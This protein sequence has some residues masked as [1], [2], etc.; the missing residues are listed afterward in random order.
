MAASLF[1]PLSIRGL[2]VKNR[3]AMS[4]MNRN[5][6]PAG[7]V[8]ENIAKF[9]RRRVDGDVGLIFTGGIAVDHPAA[10]GVYVD[11][12]CQVPLLHTPEA[13]AGWRHVVD[14]VHGGGGKIIAQL[15]HL[16]VMRLPGT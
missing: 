5:A 13:Q 12:P 16:G 14:T 10:T 9:Y 6:A 15:W 11:R 3:V 1:E 2:T 8:G 7:V 4:P